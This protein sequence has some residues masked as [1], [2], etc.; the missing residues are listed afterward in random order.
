MRNIGTIATLGLLGVAAVLTACGNKPVPPAWQTNAFEELKAFTNAYLRGDSTQADLEFARARGELASTGRF[1]N[2][3]KAELTRCAVHV[4]ALDVD[5]C[6]G[7]APMA[8]DATSAER[9]YANYLAGQWDGLPVAQLPEQ[10]R[11]VVTAGALDKV[12]D[13]VSRL[14]AAGALMRAGRI[15]PAQIQLAADTASAQ[16]WRRA[17][18]AW[19]GVQKARAAAAGDA[20][21]VAAIE[22]R[23]AL[24]TQS[25][26]P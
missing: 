15:T 2:V 7:F 19:L 13:P 1:D 9:A 25:V 16:G 18:L 14:V 8:E 11:A 4:A 6:P 21:A 22:R 12:A 3:A 24:V 20:A 5:D 10:H 26:T 23:M 17:L